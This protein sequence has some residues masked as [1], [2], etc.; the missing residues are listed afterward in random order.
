[1]Q[2]DNNVQD[3]NSLP[4]FEAAAT[5]PVQR[6]YKKVILLNTVTVAL[7]LMAV[8]FGVAWFSPLSMLKA[9]VPAVILLLSAL[10]YYCEMLVFYRRSYAIR[11]HDLIYKRGLLAVKTTI[12][13][14]NK[15]QHVAVIEGIF[16]RM[17]QLATLKVYTAG[18]N[19]ADI[20]IAGLS[21]DDAEKIKEVILSKL[22]TQ[23]DESSERQ[24]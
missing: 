17:Y 13:P 4:K 22:I 3:I 23:K 8:G 2:F 16:Q 6:D 10:V 12:V 19:D 7:I 15:I 20:G 5:T 14:F 24:D 11:N 18:S 9:V 21:K 1:M